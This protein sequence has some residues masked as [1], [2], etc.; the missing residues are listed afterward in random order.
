MLGPQ[1]WGEK[2]PAAAFLA[3]A[4]AGVGCDVGSSAGDW[5]FRPSLPKEEQRGG[6]GFT[7]SP[8]IAQGGYNSPMT[9]REAESSKVGKDERDLVRH[10]QALR[11]RWSR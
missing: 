1:L 9:R 6:Q 7:D 2:K 11:I 10:V 3:A 8:R 5:G 4:E